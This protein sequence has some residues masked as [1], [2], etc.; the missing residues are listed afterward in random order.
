MEQVTWH[1][2][3]EFCRKLGERDGKKYRMPTEAEWES[4]CRAGT[5]TEYYPGNGLQAL[6]QP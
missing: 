2:C 5:T 3:Q 6:R 1:D 4:A